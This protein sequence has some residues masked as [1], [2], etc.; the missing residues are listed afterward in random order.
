VIRQKE[1]YRRIKRQ[2]LPKDARESSQKTDRRDA[3]PNR[4][5]LSASRKGRS[6]KFISAF[7]LALFMASTASA[8]QLT[9]QTVGFFSHGHDA[10]SSCAPS[11][12]APCAPSCAAPCAPSCAAP[13]DTGCPAPA[14][15]CSEVQKISIFEKVMDIERRKNKWLLG[16][17][18]R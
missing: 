12:A 16:L 10:Y 1:A 5:P 18:G 8:G 13:C 4:F 15:G 6:M 11:C 3:Y 7:A 14:G 17:I 2:I 9:A